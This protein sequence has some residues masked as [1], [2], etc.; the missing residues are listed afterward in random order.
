MV[1]AAVLLD[2]DAYDVLNALTCYCTGEMELITQN[3]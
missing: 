1:F 3:K 2:V